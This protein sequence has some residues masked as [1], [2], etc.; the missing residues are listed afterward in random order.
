MTVDTFQKSPL[1]HQAVWLRHIEPEK[2]LLKG[3]R[4]LAVKRGMD[5]S[6]ILLSLPL[7]TFIFL[8][9]AL[10]IKLESPDGPILFVQKRTR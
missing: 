2:N 10:L 6:L 8:L 9:C 3:K 4:Y 1:Y 7:L 5:L